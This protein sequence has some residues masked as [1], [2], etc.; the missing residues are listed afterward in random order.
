MSNIRQGKGTVG[1]LFMDSAFAKNLDRTVVSLKQGASG[2]NQNM[3]AAKQS[4]LLKGIFK[5]RK[6]R[7]E[8]QPVD[9]N[10]K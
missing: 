7:G 9:E 10:K 4:F 8:T 1:K 3:E 2:F 6:K 5:K